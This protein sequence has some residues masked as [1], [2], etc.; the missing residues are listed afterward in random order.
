MALKPPP[1]TEHVGTNAEQFNLMGQTILNLINMANHLEKRIN[2]LEADL[3]SL[4][5]IDEDQPATPE[6]APAARK[7]TPAK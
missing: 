2:G 7:T 6:K 3:A 4:E 5:V 1:L